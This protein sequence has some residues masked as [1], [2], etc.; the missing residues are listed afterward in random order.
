MVIGII[1]NVSILLA[2]SMLHY[3]FARKSDL[4]YKGIREIILGVIIGFIGVILMMTPWTLQPGFG[5]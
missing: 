4:Y 2:L 3:L 1:H 5:V